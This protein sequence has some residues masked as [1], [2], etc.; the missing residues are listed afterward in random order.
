M[1]AIAERQ[2]PVEERRL[3]SEQEFIGESSSSSLLARADIFVPKI[4]TRLIPQ[5]ENVG[6][7]GSRP[8]S[9]EVLGR[10]FIT[11]FPMV[12]GEE[13]VIYSLYARA[14][15]GDKDHPLFLVA[16]KWNGYT[17]IEGV[18]TRTVPRSKAENLV[19]TA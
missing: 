12:D 5:T 18:V 15:G 13:V 11:S 2:A 6:W 14:Q 17:G 16:D 7:V 3:Q 1:P 9:R 19:F 4:V 8:V 10:V